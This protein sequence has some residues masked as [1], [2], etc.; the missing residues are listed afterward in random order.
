MDGVISSAEAEVVKSIDITDNYNPG[1]P[2]SDIKSVEGL[3]AFV[4][5]ETFLCHRNKITHLTFENN[6][7]LKKLDCSWNKITSLDVS[8]NTA[9]ESMDC[10]G[11][12]L[13]SL[14]LSNNTELECLVCSHNRLT[15]LDV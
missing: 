6:R 7:L 9:L 3:E 12:Q 5:L 10:S 8:H 14:D 2:W 13:A 4:N 1:N 15:S 11:N